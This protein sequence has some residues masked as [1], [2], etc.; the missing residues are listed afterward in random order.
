MSMSNNG[1][2]RPTEDGSLEQQDNPAK[3]KR[4]RIDDDDVVVIDDDDV[5]VIDDDDVAVIDD[6]DD[7]PEEEE[8]ADAAAAHDSSPSFQ[9][10]KA[11]HPKVDPFFKL[12]GEWCSSV[13]HLHG[14]Q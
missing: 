2:K 3:K 12:D 10:I 6:D 9:G 5:V 7:A 13:H 14:Y 4:A 1:T 11:V 8:P